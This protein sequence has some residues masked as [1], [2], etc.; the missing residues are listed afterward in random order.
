MLRILRLLL[1]VVILLLSYS[2]QQV[3]D[4]RSLPEALS[5]SAD[6]TPAEEA[7]G[8]IAQFI[9]TAARFIGTVI[10]SVID[11]DRMS[12]N[13]LI[14]FGMFVVLLTSLGFGIVSSRW[15]PSVFFWQSE[16]WLSGR[17]V[18]SNLGNPDFIAI[19]MPTDPAVD[20][21]V[22]LNG[23]HVDNVAEGKTVATSVHSSVAQR[24]GLPIAVFAFAL[25]IIVMA[26]VSTFGLDTLPLQAI[27][28]AG[29]ALLILGT[30]LMGRGSAIASQVNGLTPHYS[31]ITRGRVVLDDGNSAVNISPTSGWRW[32]LAILIG[33]SILYL[34]QLANLPAKLEPAI[35]ET[36]LQALAILR[37]EVETLFFPG[38]TGLPMLAYIPSALAIQLS[39]HPLIGVRLAGVGSGALMIL[40]TW[41][42]ACELFRRVP[43]YGRYGTLIEDD[44]R[45]IAIL[46]ALIVAT[47]H[48]TLHFSRIPIYLAPIAWGCLGLWALL[49]GLRQQSLFSLVISGMM[50]GLASVLHTGG[51]FY[52]MTAP[53]W[54]IGAWLLQRPWVAGSHGVRV[55]G[56]IV[57]LSGIG[58]VMLPFWGVWVRL[59]LSYVA[60]LQGNLPLPVTLDARQQA[61]LLTRGVEYLFFDN[62]RL[63][64]FTFNIY[65]N[66]GSLFAPSSPFLNNW[67]A[68]LLFLGIGALF[69]NLDRLVGWLLIVTLGLGIILAA[70]N[71]EAPVWL[72]LLPLL[73]LLAIII[74][75]TLDRIR[76][77]LL[78]TAG[79]WLEQTTVY[80]ALGLVV[81][82]GCQGWFQYYNYALRQ[83][84][85]SSHIG[86]AIQSMA[87]E[88]TAVLLFSNSFVDSAVAQSQSGSASTQETEQDALPA[89]GPNAS[90]PTT[91]VEQSGLDPTIIDF[92]SSDLSGPRPRQ[93]TLIGT[94]PAA[95]EISTPTRFLIQPENQPWLQELE[96]RYGMG[97]VTAMRNLRGDPVL[98]LFDFWPPQQ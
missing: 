37:G 72:R 13:E 66:S 82:A 55:K 25:I 90:F 24:F 73:P 5:A 77:L 71:L 64:L 52:L 29:L 26:Q 83:D 59:P 6:S 97:K 92:I 53:L 91:L 80:L 36:G 7:G 87:P 33:S 75:F 32:I 48:V 22:N 88:Q 39:G 54:W 60:Y 69:L 9:S 3:F 8:Q 68:P 49:R 28:I 56:L 44:G 86:R 38:A 1:F 4:Q 76:V 95:E 63:T 51:L 70:V 89:D 19:N 18:R 16:D 65:P 67:L 41:L 15:L 17:W 27:W 78:E 40:G 81:W 11:L 50:I 79:V 98:F 46:A 84:A 61:L 10:S 34:L 35:A 43:R 45:W 30:I 62:L 20:P 47:S 42:L 31:L 58:A 93:E 74:A 57:W 2:A 12:P 94:W 14:V 96:T 85:S 21:T 23:G